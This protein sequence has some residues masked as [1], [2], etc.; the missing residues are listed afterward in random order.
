M[1]RPFGLH[2]RANQPASL[3]GFTSLPDLD[4]HRGPVV[5]RCGWKSLRFSLLK[6]TES[7]RTRYPHRVISPPA[8][9]IFHGH[10]GIPLPA[11][12]NGPS[13]NVRH[14][15][16]ADRA[17]IAAES[18]THM[19]KVVLAGLHLLTREQV[20]RWNVKPAGNCLHQLIAGHGKAIHIAAAG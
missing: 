4:C 7:P 5:R 11:R 6:H 19:T 3:Q 14:D 10:R 2:I 15:E 13:L 17:V 8:A 1:R 18:D 16:R 9:V 20:A 12:M